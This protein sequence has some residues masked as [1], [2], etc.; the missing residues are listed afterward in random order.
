MA[1]IEQHEEWPIKILAD[2]LRTAGLRIGPRE[3]MQALVVLVHESEWP[4]EQLRA[5]LASLFVISSSDRLAFDRL[6]DLTFPKDERDSV[7]PFRATPQPP[8]RPPPPRHPVG[9]LPPS[10]LA[11]PP[12]KTA[13][14]EV[15][16][17][18]P[19]RVGRDGFWLTARRAASELLGDALGWAIMLLVPCGIAGLVYYLSSP[20][21]GSGI[22]NP[23]SAQNEPPWTAWLFSALLAAGLMG[24]ILLALRWFTRDKPL[25]QEK[26]REPT[27]GGAAVFRPGL[28]GG[29]PPARVE[30][31][32]L[33]A[34]CEVFGYS[35]GEDDERELDADATI[36]AVIASGGLPLIRHPASRVL[37]V[38]VVLIDTTSL[39]RHWNSTP[40]E[41]V[42]ALSE[43]GLDVRH[44]PFDGSLHAPGR[45][46][47]G[48]TALQPTTTGLQ[49]RN[50][51][52]DE[53]YSVVMVF[54]DG[55]RWQGA[56]TQL[57]ASLSADGPILWFDDRDRELWDSRL[58]SLRLARIP[59]YEA[60][61][62]AVEEALRAAYAPGRG[63]GS[64][65]RTAG[66]ALARR[67]RASL[68]DE[69][70]AL[71]GN[72]IGWARHCALFEPISV[73]L[74]DS[75]RREFHPTLPWL[76]FSRVCALPGST[77]GPE[78]LRFDPRV[79]SLLLTGFAR[80]EPERLRD[81]VVEHIVNAVTKAGAG[82][83]PGTPANALW[84]LSLQRVEVH[85]HPDDA[86]REIVALRQTGLVEEE[87]VDRFL[88]RL[89]P[90]SLKQASD[91]RRSAADPPIPVAKPLRSAET[92][93]ALRGPDAALSRARLPVWQISTPEL[94]LD[95]AQHA[96]AEGPVAAFVGDDRVFVRQ[97]SPTQQDGERLV[98]VSVH[99]G[100]PVGEGFD[101][102]GS[103]TA[104]DA[105]DGTI[106]AG[107]SNGELFAFF[108]AEEAQPDE[109]PQAA[110][111]LQA[112]SDRMGRLQ[113]VFADARQ[114]RALGLSSG[115][116][117]ILTPGKPPPSVSLEFD[118][119]VTAGCAF[120]DLVLLANAYG[121]L[122]AVGASGEKVPIKDDNLPGP[123]HALAPLPF[124][125]G[126]GPFPKLL[127]VA[128][129]GPTG[130]E[131]AY[132][133]VFD[134]EAGSGVGFPE[135]VLRRRQKIAVGARPV[136]L[137]I[138]QDGT[139][140]LV[141]MER[142]IDIVDTASGLSLLAGDADL[143]LE[144]LG[145]SDP[146][147]M[148]VAAAS[149][150]DRRIAVLTAEPWRLEVRRLETQVFEQ[151]PAAEPPPESAPVFA[152]TEG[153]A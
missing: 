81:A 47:D 19:E 6:F 52:D 122:M 92:I 55:N 131:R 80:L 21:G 101:L 72:A 41:I 1:A 66:N 50:L 132:V 22:V 90:L 71:L 123:I 7:N 54:S 70:R 13:E 76:T 112:S 100:I 9:R 153:P 12:E 86:V 44:L 23:N 24:P 128:Y 85:R 65:A 60:T 51:A 121:Q 95:A 136:K 28:V 87:P 124:R 89:Q 73:A 38:V 42:R 104:L 75:I 63:I 129:S 48:L 45:P 140:L 58:D 149:L 10:P 102:S 17:S 146:E 151:E 96:F 88:R 117:T 37:P 34:I 94:R 141:V 46:D 5:V 130:D 142:A 133:A 69:T 67:R 91:G 40:E 125:D 59:I 79:R 135:I 3:Y 39:G 114:R 147:K 35:N 64:P 68:A 126:A 109:A 4:R 93:E 15:I 74:A 56:D 108:R 144:S 150:A 49:L 119:P 113:A 120:G 116:L 107:D 26:P 31:E 115:L 8:A 62:A 118:G 83:A 30:P 105:G 27:A 148:R 2:G 14:P 77:I 111:Y 137:E 18:P 127:A 98:P 36:E 53:P 152:Q 43:R 84:Q 32:R 20:G 25:F 143:L 78:G 145:A 29:P 138:S 33:K 106:A 82:T 61:G 139:T 103:L 99:S 134:V 11:G 110:D 97:P 57:L 16:P